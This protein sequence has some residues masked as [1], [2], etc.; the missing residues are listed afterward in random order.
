MTAIRVGLSTSVYADRPLERRH[1]REIAN[2]GFDGV[3]LA[4]TPAHFDGTDAAAVS[5]RDGWLREPGWSF[6]CAARGRSSRGLA[7]S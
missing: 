7:C 6:T 5:R 1:L 4:A 2:H 3:E